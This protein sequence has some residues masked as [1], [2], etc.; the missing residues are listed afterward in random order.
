VAAAGFLLIGVL[1]TSSVAGPVDDPILPKERNA[2]ADLDNAIFV[3]DQR[4]QEP[5]EPMTATPGQTAEAVR[6]NRQ[7][8]CGR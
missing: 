4:R 5:L 2:R 3:G 1:P 8:V 6:I 7:R